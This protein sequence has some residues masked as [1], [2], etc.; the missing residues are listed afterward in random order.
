MRSHIALALVLALAAAPAAQEP[1]V[2][3][4]LEVR[5]FNGTED[6]T[7]QSRFTV[8]RAGERQTSVT[9]API[10]MGDGQ[11]ALQVP[12]GVYD[13]QAIHERDGKVVNIRWANRLVVMPYPDENG[14]APRSHQLQATASA[15][16]RSARAGPVERSPDRR[17]STNRASATKPI[18]DAA[19]GG[20]GYA[21]LRRACRPL[22]SAGADRRYRDLHDR[23]RSAARTHPAD[24]RAE[25]RA[26]RKDRG[27]GIGRG[28]DDVA[29]SDGIRAG[30][31]PSPLGLELTPAAAGR[32]PRRRP[33]V[34]AGAAAQ[35][36]RPPDEH[37]DRGRIGALHA[38]VVRAGGATSGDPAG[39]RR[40]SSPASV[41]LAPARSCAPT[42][43]CR[44]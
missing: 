27:A 10:K 20:R 37:P 1:Q 30:T 12:S 26:A 5:A 23:P 40:R 18:G 16:C 15:R 4:N 34:R 17:R 31:M 32:G 14:P 43:A 9:P 44:G 33:R 29:L 24:R 6:V 35:G 8:H 25:E 3:L 42:A 7:A 11:P 36:R 19:H 38:D 22:R 2:S 39:S 13:V 28:F 21:A 41:S